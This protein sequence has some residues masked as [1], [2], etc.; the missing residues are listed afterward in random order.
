MSFVV[1]VVVIVIIIYLTSV[2]SNCYW[3]YPESCRLLTIR[4]AY[5]TLPDLCS[6]A[7]SCLFIPLSMFHSTGLLPVPITMLFRVYPLVSRIIW[8]LDKIAN[9]VPRSPEAEF[10][11]GT[12]ESVLTSPPVEP[13]LRHSQ[14]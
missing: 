11:G 9:F 4:V 6:P 1:V 10:G 3:V 5:K 7:T 13:Y 2:I 8:Q 12:Q 14:V